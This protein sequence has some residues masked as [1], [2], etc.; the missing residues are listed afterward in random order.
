MAGDGDVIYWD[1]GAHRPNDN[2]LYLPV[3]VPFSKA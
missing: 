2:E 1:E 3:M